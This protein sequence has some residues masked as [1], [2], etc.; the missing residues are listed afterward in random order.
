MPEMLRV[1]PAFFNGMKKSW[2]DLPP[3]LLI[4]TGP[5][6]DIGPQANGYSIGLASRRRPHSLASSS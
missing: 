3:D 4:K 1:L 6:L 2:T 5:I